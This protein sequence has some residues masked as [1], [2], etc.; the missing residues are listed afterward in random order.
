MS[1]NRE[2]YRKGR[3]QAPRFWDDVSDSSS[4]NWNSGKNWGRSCFVAFLVGSWSQALLFFETSGRRTGTK[5]SIRGRA[6]S[7]LNMITETKNEH[8]FDGDGRPV[9][10]VMGSRQFHVNTPPTGELG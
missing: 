9:V 10:E 5:S 2:R 4:S 3:G 7:I 8:K 1:S 6:G